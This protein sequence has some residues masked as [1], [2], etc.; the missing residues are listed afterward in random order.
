MTAHATYKL[1]VNHTRKLNPETGEDEI[2]ASDSKQD[3]IVNSISTSEG[4]LHFSPVTIKIGQ[5]LSITRTESDIE[6]H[7]E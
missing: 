4:V 1:A 2:I 5:H 6:I 3:F 7:V